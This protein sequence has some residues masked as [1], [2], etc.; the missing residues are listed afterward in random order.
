MRFIGSRGSR[1]PPTHQPISLDLI[2]SP[3]ATSILGLIDDIVPRFQL[4]AS[5]A[6]P[7]RAAHVNHPQWPQSCVPRS[8]A[9]PSPS[10]PPSNAHRSPPS[11]P[12]P[13][14]ARSPSTSDQQLS[15]APPSMPPSATRSCLLCP[16]R[17]S[18]PPTSLSPCLTRTT[19]MAATT[20]VLSASCLLV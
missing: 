3:L 12:A 11:P 4:R 19:H 7:P 8:S 13:S 10:P 14:T 1:F 2:P 16:K 18:A 5:H 6:S 20:G 15:S 9:P 17:S